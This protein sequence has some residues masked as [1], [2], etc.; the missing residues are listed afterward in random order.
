MGVSGAGKGTLMAS[1][2]LI[3]SPEL[4]F[5]LSYKSRPMRRWEKNGYDAHFVSQDEFE[6]S[7]KR[8]EFLEYALIHEMHYGWTKYDDVVT[9]GIEKQ[10]KVIKELDIHGLEY[11]HSHHKALLSHITTIFLYIPQ[12]VL[13]E[14]IAIRG[15][16]IDDHELQK[17]LQSA[18]Y[19]TKRS[20]EL[21]DHIIDASLSP[22]EIFTQVREIIFSN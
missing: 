4:Y 6:E 15:D 7:I 18:L 9:Q 17:R 13:P 5:P 1:L 16:N 19:E 8:W 12:E 14:R 21:C 3:P 2:K 22:E 11:I 20:Q 10:K